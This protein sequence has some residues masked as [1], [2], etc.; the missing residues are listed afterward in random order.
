[1]DLRPDHFL[2]QSRRTLLFADPLWRSDWRFPFT[3][4]SP[5]KIQDFFI[6]PVPIQIGKW[7]RGRRS[8]D[9]SFFR[10][11]DLPFLHWFSGWLDFPLW[12]SVL[13]TFVEGLLL[14]W[15][16]FFPLRLYLQD[17]RVG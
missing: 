4:S 7:R 3:K 6:T 16:V 5:N 17:V 14:I 15:I 2:G 13:P 12:F 8:S 9:P 11:F 1:M 10:R